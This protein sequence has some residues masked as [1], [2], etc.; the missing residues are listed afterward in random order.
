MWQVLGLWLALSFL[1][2]SGLV[3]GFELLGSF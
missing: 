2:R 3:V 1:A